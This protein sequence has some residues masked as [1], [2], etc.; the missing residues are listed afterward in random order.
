LT[1]PA[2]ASIATRS[3]DLLTSPPY[4]KNSLGVRC[5]TDA[6]LTA[7]DTTA[8]LPPAPTPLPPT[9]GNGIVEGWAVL[10]AQEHYGGLPLLEDQEAGVGYLDAFRETLLQAGWAADHIR[11]IRDEADRDTVS[12]AVRWLAQ[13]ADG[14]DRVL[15]Y[16]SAQ[17]EYLDRYLRWHAFF[18]PLWARV[19]GQ[20]VL[21]VDT[22][23]GEYFARAVSGDGRGGLAIGSVRGG[24]CGWFGLAAD[25]TEFAGP[26]FTHYFLTALRQPAADVDSDGRVSVQEAARYADAAQRAYIRE[27]IFPVAEFHRR[28]AAPWEDDPAR[29][30]NYP[31][32]WIGDWAGRPV[33]LDL[34]AQ[35]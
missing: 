20:R 35:Q 18:P 4:H 30:P 15:F 14:D 31:S 3:Y 17:S 10:A 8:L 24:Q 21:I 6:P 19:P 22:C 25:G 2:G 5:A 32:A 9:P 27:T 11:V 26:A 13:N 7:V 23:D 33:F 16:Y 29:D 28:F 12:E 34:P 1:S